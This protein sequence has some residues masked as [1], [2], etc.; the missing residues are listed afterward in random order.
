MEQY[1]ELSPKVRDAI[2]QQKPIVALESTVI[3]HGL[4]YPQNIE[5]AQS[6][7]SIILEHGA[8]PATIA[9]IHGKIKVGLTDKEIV[10]MAEAEQIKKSS[11]RDIPFAVSQKLTAAT[12]V[13]ATMLI[14]E[15]AGI[16]VFCYRR[17]WGCSSR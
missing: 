7:E 14:A 10:Y 13:A 8:V 6:M 16:N 17:N 5:T 2:Q 15:K 12:T 11:R 1:I 3:S 9:I 4:P